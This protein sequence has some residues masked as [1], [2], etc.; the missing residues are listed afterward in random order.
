MKK[1]CIVYG[2]SDSPMRRRAL[3]ILTECLLDY[4]VEYPVAV[5]MEAEV[6]A[7]DFRRFVIGTKADNPAVCA[8]SPQTLNRAEQYCIRVEDDTVLIEGTDE[9]GV[10]YGCVDFYNKYVLHFEFTHESSWYHKNIF[11]NPLPDFTL[12]SSPSTL[13]R[14]IW[15][16]GHVI[17]DYR[18]FIDAL[19]R[20]K[21][22]SIIIWNDFPP[23]NAREMIAYAHDCGIRVIWGYPWF[24]DTRC[25]Q[26]DIE[27]ALA[28]GDAILAQYERDYRD[29]GGDGIYFQSFT[30]LNREKIGDVLI[31][32]AVT[33]FVNRTAAKFYEKYPDIDLQFGLHANSVKNK[34]EYIARVDPRIRIVWENCGAFPFSYIPKQVEDFPETAA[35]VEKII[36]LRGEGERFGAVTKGFTKLDWKAFEH[37]KGPMLIGESSPQMKAN[38]ILR[39]HKIW[40]YIQAHWLSHADAACEM[41]RLMQ[42]ETAGAGEIS[43]LVEDGMLEAEIPYVVAL[44]AEMLWDGETELREMMS[45]VALREWVTF[46]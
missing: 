1:N 35:L 25:D 2:T 8:L 44:Y 18:G 46:I 3:E 4:T 29:L 19:V 17:Y 24:W 40:R 42:R 16:W 39:K 26:I 34:L 20:L 30:E 12:V 6:P 22:N 13:K 32:E 38:R 7:G 9:H 41:I 28:S 5:P 11:E 45:A 43:A 37:P 36:H 33:E 10:L 27:K 14:G 21:M 15:T 23:V 31:A